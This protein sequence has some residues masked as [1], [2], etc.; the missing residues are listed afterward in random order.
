MPDIIAQRKARADAQERAEIL[1]KQA[2]VNARISTAAVGL[3]TGGAGLGTAAGTASGLQS[4][5]VQ[6]CLPGLHHVRT[7]RAGQCL[8]LPACIIVGTHSTH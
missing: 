7:M 3:A 8:L 4:I 5:S 6:P 1:R 2:E